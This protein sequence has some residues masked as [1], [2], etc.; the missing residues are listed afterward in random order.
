MGPGPDVLIGEARIALKTAEINF[1][2]PFI[3]NFYSNKLLLYLNS[4]EKYPDFLKTNKKKNILS[5]S[6]LKMF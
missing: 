1:Y 5:L 6:F 3:I 4:E 2:K